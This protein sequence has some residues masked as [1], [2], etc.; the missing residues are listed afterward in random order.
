M[1]PSLDERDIVYRRF[2][3]IWRFGGFRSEM[4]RHGCAT[5]RICQWWGFGPQ[6]DR[7]RVVA[8]QPD[9]ILTSGT[10]TLDAY[11]AHTFNMTSDGL[12]NFDTRTLADRDWQIGTIG[13]IVG[14][15][16]V[17]QA[18]IAQLAARRETILAQ[19]T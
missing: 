8:L 15:A 6:A 7:E 12:I 13:E 16:E 11:E 4:W 5:G 2:K 18:I 19:R 3:S 17:A 1:R 14:Q 9:L 10:S